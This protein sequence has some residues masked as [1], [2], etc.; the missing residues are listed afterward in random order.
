MFIDGTENL[1]DVVSGRAY[2]AKLVF[3]ERGA[4]VIPTSRQH[5]EAK[6]D[7][8]SYEDNYAGNALAAMVRRDA[9]EIRFHQKFSD[10]VV[11]AITDRL[12][13]LE[14]FACLK[15][16]VVSYQGRVLRPRQTPSGSTE[17]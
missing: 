9:I 7:G 6:A 4:I 13:N 8:I 17:S 11:A 12:L 16:V 3:N 5:R 2:D 14:P 15:G 10:K 1:S